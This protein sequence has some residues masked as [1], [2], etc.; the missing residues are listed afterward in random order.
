LA[1]DASVVSGQY[2][3]EACRSFVDRET[4][5]LVSYAMTSRTPV[6]MSPADGSVVHASEALTFSWTKGPGARLRPLERILGAVE[7]TAYAHGSITGDGYVLTFVHGC[8]EVMRVMTTDT[9]WTADS[10][11]SQR[12]A[13]F[14]GPI[15]VRVIWAKYV[16]NTIATGVVP[17]A[18]PPITITMAP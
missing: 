14:L 10:A 8:D 6:L 15:T 7:G 9:S 12:L 16:Q 5:G 2:T 18:S 1:A 3:D 11:S 17:A 13:G 4:Q